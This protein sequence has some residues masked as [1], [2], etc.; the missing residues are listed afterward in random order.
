MNTCI[1]IGAGMTGLT[2]AREL[3]A[4][5][6][7]VTVLDKG[8]G[9]GGRMATRRIENSRADHGAQYFSVRTPE[10]KGAIQDLQAHDVA[11]AWDLAEADIEH[12]RYF[13]TNGMST[14]PKYLAKDLNIKLQ[15]RATLIEADGTGC[16]VTTEAGHT[17]SADA[18][19]LT[20]PAP[21]AITLLSDSQ[22]DL[23]EAGQH[24][25]ESIH[26]QP[27]LAVMVLLN[28]PSQIPAP[29]LVK[30]DDGDLETVTDNQQK[31]IA[32]EQPTV[33]IHASPAFSLAHLEG[34]LKAAGQLLLDQ[35]T[36]WI[37]AN[38]IVEYQTHRWRYSL[39][40]VRSPDPFAALDTPF[41]LLM[42]GDGFGMGNVE[43]AF[44]SG[45]QMARRLAE[46]RRRAKG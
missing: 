13:G 45:L 36:D 15:E 4:Q 7:D 22:I 34:D 10:F 12:P 38:S 20:I 23:N 29:G 46:E 40:E 5:G 26:Y 30:Y 16:R 9:V 43:G 37:P 35:L 27:C 42:G 8:R 17:F 39:A 32:P 44:Q 28:E 1:V 19:I 11:E 3:T 31:G 6:W 24:A 41:P 14:I 33:T 2:A 25:F 21:Q 18:L